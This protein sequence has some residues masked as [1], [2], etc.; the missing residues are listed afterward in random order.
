MRKEDRKIYIEYKVRA[1]FERRD[2]GNSEKWI[3]KAIDEITEDWIE[4]EVSSFDI[5]FDF[6]LHR[7]VAPYSEQAR[8]ELNEV[9]DVKT[10][11]E[12]QEWSY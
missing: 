8:E 11:N 5:A 6:E 7:L 9:R 2:L 3:E 4:K 1:D 10:S 12:N